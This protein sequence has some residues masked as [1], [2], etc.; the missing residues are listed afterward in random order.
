MSATLTIRDE[1]AGGQT[2]HEFDLE[3]L[4]ETI[5]VRTA[6]TIAARTTNPAAGN[7]ARGP[8]S[9]NKQC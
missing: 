1:S 9:A 5:T 8:A 7:G 4:T 3:F 2:L 6:N